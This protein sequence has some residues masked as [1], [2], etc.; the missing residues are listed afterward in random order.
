MNNK[1]KLAKYKEKVNQVIQK[2]VYELFKHQPDNYVDWMIEYLQLTRLSKHSR[3]SLIVE[4]N[5]SSDEEAFE[6]IDQLPQ[7][8]GNTKVFRSSVSAEVFGIHNKKENF[9]PRVI[10]KTEEQKKQIQEKLM[11]VFMFQ[12]L[13]ENEKK[14]VVD[15]MEEKHFGQNEWVIKQGDDGNE[16]YIVFSGELN[17]YRKMNSQD[18]EPKFLKEYSAGDM[19]G[20]LALLYNAPRAASIQ[21]KNDA[22]LFA[23]DRSTFNNIVKDATIK[24]RE[25]YEE[26]LSKVE[27]LQSM[28][29]YEK[30]QVCDGLKEANYSAG[31][32][33]IKEGEEGDKFYMV[34]EGN[35][36][37][38]REV[39]GQQEEVLRYKT[40]DYFGELALIHKVPRQATVKAET[41]CN[42]VYLDINSFIRLLGP[43]ANILKR[44]A[45]AYK[46]F[47]KN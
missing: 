8:S 40:G 14:I 23:L 1:E 7:P 35:L 24:K 41:D 36:I 13:G 3:E 21:A 44:N 42:L 30:T 26:V 31:E 18:T 22:V 5:V 28:D 6:E 25:Q 4:Y 16:L 39:D 43:V 15:A 46:K 19:F 10:Q 38:Y 47:I 27:L 9:Q 12:A 20:E 45:E 11:K 34:A 2:M 32:I 17:C 33:I 37:A 29:A